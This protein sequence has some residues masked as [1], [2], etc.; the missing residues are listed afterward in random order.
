MI[1]MVSAPNAKGAATKRAVGVPKD[2]LKTK[3]QPFEA[4]DCGAHA[5]GP[6]LG[7]KRIRGG[8]FVEKRWVITCCTL[9]A[10]SDR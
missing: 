5:L 8:F 6:S 3:L 4:S 9:S 7:G 2:V 10:G 1:N